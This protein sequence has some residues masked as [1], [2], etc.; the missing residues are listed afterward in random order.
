MESRI[1]RHATK[2]TLFA[3]L[4]LAACL[5]GSPANAQSN[6]QGKFTLQHETRWGQAVLPPGDYQLTIADNNQG[7]KMLVLF[8]ATNHRQIAVELAGIREG[9]SKG[10]SALL[11]GR[12]G[13]QRVVHSLR[14]AEL[15]E[16]FVYERPS[17]QGR[18]FEEADQ[19]R[20]VAVLVTK[21]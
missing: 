13:T 4:L 16:T 9:S 11:I 18:P 7:A 21:K 17:T 14:I 2:A 19:T 15:G 20:A 10:A 8:D 5:F 1:V 6:F 12:Q 3:A